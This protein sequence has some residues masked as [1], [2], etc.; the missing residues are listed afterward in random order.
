MAKKAQKK[1]ATKRKTAKKTTKKRTAKKRAASGGKK[2]R[3]SLKKLRDELTHLSSDLEAIIQAG[4][5]Q[6]GTLD[7][8]QKQQAQDT[9]DALDTA[10]QTF[11][12]GTLLVPY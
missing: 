2:P 6:T 10:L 11:R 5:D 1:K 12:C 8:Y 7:A 3:P 9:K 4:E